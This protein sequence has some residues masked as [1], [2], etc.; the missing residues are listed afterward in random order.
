[1]SVFHDQADFLTAVN[2]TYPN[3]TEMALSLAARLV[4]EEYDELNIELA[5]L[6]NHMQEQSLIPT[7][8]VA[9]LCKEAID[10]VYVTCQLLNTLVGPD[11][12]H[13]MFQAVHENNM[14]KAR[15]LKVRDD[16]KVE[17]PE[18]FQK[19]TLESFCYD[20]DFSR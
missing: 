19:V 6:E 20:I 3:C 15:N 1:M 4:D 2:K 8:D 17:K 9:K 10:V 12:A 14:T 5:C 18:G 16:G 11:V 13:A 7:E